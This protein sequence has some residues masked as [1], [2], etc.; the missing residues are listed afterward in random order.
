MTFQTTVY[1]PRE[2]RELFINVLKFDTEQ[3]FDYMKIDTDG[4]TLLYSGLL[5]PYN[6]TTN[7]SARITFISD[8]TTTYEGIELDVFAL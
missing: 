1:K 2:Y 3:Y 6:I 7:S 5:E 4:K 8:E